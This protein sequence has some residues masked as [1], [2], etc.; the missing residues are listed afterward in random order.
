MRIGLRLCKALEICACTYVM[1]RAT[2]RNK[3]N[4]QMCIVRYNVVYS[5]DVGL[6]IT[7]NIVTERDVGILA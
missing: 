5:V 1:S 2:R 7:I 6:D 3:V 4:A